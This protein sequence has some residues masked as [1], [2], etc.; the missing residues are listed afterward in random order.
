M[1]LGKE[2]SGQGDNPDGRETGEG[3]REAERFMGLLCLLMRRKMDSEVKE[4]T[5]WFTR[6]S[7][8][9]LCSSLHG[10]L[11]VRSSSMTSF[12][13]RRRGILQLWYKRLGAAL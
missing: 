8:L 10:L 9:R 5:W 6:Y 7:V 2:K 4:I 1:P 13:L 11:H 3:R 12:S